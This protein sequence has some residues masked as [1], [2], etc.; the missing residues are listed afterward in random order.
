[1]RSPEPLDAL[2]IGGGPAGLMAADELAAA[3]RRVV[4][5]EARPSVGRK[6]LMAG[7]SGL[8]LTMD[9]GPADFLAAYS[10][11][12]DWLAPLLAD[13]GPVQVSTWA[14]NLGIDV[15]T[16]SSGR[17][18]PVWM[19]ASPLLRVWL[20]R[21][22]EQGVA[23]RTRWR[24]QGFD[25]PDAVFATPEGERLLAPRVT[26]L[27]L[28]GGSWARL[29]SDGAWTDILAAAGVPIAPFRPS[30]VGFLR[31]WSPAMTRHFGAPVKPVRLMAG[32]HAVRGEF[33]ISALGVEGGGIY[34]LGPALRDGAGL[35]LDLIP[36]RT[37][38]DATSRL[39][40]QPAKA[41]LANRLRRALNLHTCQDRAPARMRPRNPRRTRGDCRGAQGLAA[42]PR[43]PAPARRSDLD[44]R[45]RDARRMRRKPDAAR[46]ARHLRCRRDARLGRA[47][48][49]LPADGLPRD[50]PPR[51]T[52]RGALGGRLGLNPALR[53]A[54]PAR[55]RHP[56]T[57]PMRTTA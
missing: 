28:G 20:S 7:K 14:R 23:L 25:G 53:I 19:K 47:H 50:R 21:L 52:I 8:N 26:M 41:S 42:R 39:A 24:W 5:A 56:E 1:M 57:D 12:A 49:G 35:T 36:D 9:T 51:R 43:R 48:G 16:G 31:V 38:A 22:S 33:V 37:A 27:A 55:T 13:F 30:N 2:V 6:L 40:S 34:A 4:V 15:F 46:P 17:I 54:R 32:G 18:F 10:T 3:G 44:R 11:G 45:R 29:G